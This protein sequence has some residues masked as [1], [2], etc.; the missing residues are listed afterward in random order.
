[1]AQQ[2]DPLSLIIKT[3]YGGILGQAG[4]LDQAIRIYKDSLELNPN[5]QQAL[6]FLGLVY[7]YKSSYN[8]AIMTYKKV[9]DL[10]KGQDKLAQSFIGVAYALAGEKENATKALHGILELSQR[11]YFSPVLIANIYFARGDIDLGF[12]WLE[13]GFEIGDHWISWIKTFPFFDEVK[14]DP[15]YQNLLVRIG[16]PQ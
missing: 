8:H 5:F 1:L 3:A 9:L 6:T 15:R 2:L 14:S 16:F 12:T 7:L 4:R 10:S 11:Q 13:K